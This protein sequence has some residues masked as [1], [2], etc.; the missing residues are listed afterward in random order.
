M[1]KPK[2]SSTDLIW[3]FIEKLKSFGDCAL[4][5]AIA[6]LPTENGWRAITSRKDHRAHPRC[7]KR[8][9][10]VQKQL[11]QIYVLAKDHPPVDGHRKPKLIAKPSRAAFVRPAIAFPPKVAKR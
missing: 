7:A 9:E 2:I 5:V 1:A 6:I 8:I 10:R 11:R 3:V 4:T